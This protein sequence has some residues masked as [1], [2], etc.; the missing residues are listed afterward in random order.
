MANSQLRGVVADQNDQQLIVQGQ[1]PSTLHIGHPPRGLGDQLPTTWSLQ[2]LL[3][4]TFDWCKLGLSLGQ[5]LPFFW[6]ILEGRF[7]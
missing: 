1:P 4:T 2:R 6:K 3:P 7:H 5:F